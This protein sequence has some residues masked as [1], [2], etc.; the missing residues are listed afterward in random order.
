MKTSAPKD[1][2]KHISDIDI[3]L[4]EISTHQTDLVQINE[5]LFTAAEHSNSEYGDR[6]LQNLQTRLIWFQ[7][8]LYNS[9]K[10]LNE[11]KLKLLEVVEGKTE[12]NKKKLDDFYNFCNETAVKIN[13]KID[14]FKIDLE[15]TLSRFC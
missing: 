4:D 12:R 8:V 5:N 7:K 14:R 13:G 9:E 3:M 2:K 1:V 11:H 15:K 6:E 10:V